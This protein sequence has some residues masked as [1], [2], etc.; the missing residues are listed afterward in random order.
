M[1]DETKDA[2]ER[3]FVITGGCYELNHGHPVYV[4]AKDELWAIT[5]IGLTVWTKEEWERVNKLMLDAQR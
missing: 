1:A 4:I 3:E 5:G 2:G